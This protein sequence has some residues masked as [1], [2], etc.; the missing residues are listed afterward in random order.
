MGAVDLLCSRNAH[1]QNVLV[2]RAQSR[3]DQATLENEM[4]KWEDAR[5]RRPISPHP[6]ERTS[7]LGDRELPDHPS[8]SQ[9]AHARKV[10]VRCAQ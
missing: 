3:I 5:S 7:E 10:L 6:S 1:D 9:N 8:C 4:G 2:R